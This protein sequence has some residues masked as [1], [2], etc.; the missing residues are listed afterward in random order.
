MGREVCLKKKIYLH[1]GFQS[2]GALLLDHQG[3]PLTKPFMLKDVWK[4]LQPC[5]RAWQFLIKLQQTVIH[6]LTWALVS[7]SQFMSP[8]WRLCASLRVSF[9]AF[10]FRCVCDVTDFLSIYTSKA[11]QL[12]TL[13]P[14]QIGLDQ[15]NHFFKAS[16][17]GSWWTD[18]KVIYKRGRVDVGT[19]PPW[20]RP[21]GWGDWGGICSAVYA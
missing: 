18:H 14:L 5:S 11:S 13:L 1:R 7:W 12:S 15:W 17:L 3:A 4:C 16:V 19:V 20:S 21:R 8:L 6:I 2:A 9:S 10:V